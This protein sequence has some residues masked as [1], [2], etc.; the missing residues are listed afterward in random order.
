VPRL[1][2]TQIP[3]PASADQNPDP[4]WGSY[5]LGVGSFSVSV[6]TNTLTL[7]AT[8]DGGTLNDDGDRL[9]IWARSLDLSP[10][11]GIDLYGIERLGKLLASDAWPTDV[12]TPFNAAPELTF[13]LNGLFLDDG[14]GGWITT[15]RP[16]RIT[17]EP[18]STPV[19]EP[20]TL[21]LLGTG[22]AGAVGLRWRDRKHR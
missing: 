18:A 19:P 11:V 12:A 5:S 7:P 10:P 20:S 16:L 21:L 4:A 6:G 1:V 3:H 2:P 15:G 9:V 13:A 22:L 14:S 8:V 17:Q